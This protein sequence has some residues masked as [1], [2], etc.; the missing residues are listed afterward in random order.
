MHT[1]AKKKMEE[2]CTSGRVGKE[3]CAM[4]KMLGSKVE[5]NGLECFHDRWRK[6]AP[7]VKAGSMA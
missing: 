2:S 1:P 6:V 4:T 7:K 5:V 3:G